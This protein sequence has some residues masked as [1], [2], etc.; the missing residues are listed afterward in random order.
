MLSGRLFLKRVL[1]DATL[2]FFMLVSSAQG[3][4][5][6][7]VMVKNNRFLPQEIRIAAGDTVK[8]LNQERRT[9]HSVVLPDAQGGESERFFPAENWQHRF[10]QAGIYPYYCG[11][12]PDMTGVI[13]VIAQ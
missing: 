12:H 1:L 7:E 9:S 2:V 5:T 6:V 8:W 4:Q 10:D 3:Q 13:E 11:P